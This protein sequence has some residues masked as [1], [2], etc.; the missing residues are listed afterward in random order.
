MTS[1]YVWGHAVRVRAVLATLAVLAGLMTWAPSPAA[2]AVAFQTEDLRVQSGSG[3]DRVELDVTFY[4]PNSASERE[5][6]AAIIFPHGYGGTKEQPK[7]QATKFARLGYFGVTYSARGFGESTGDISLN[8]PEYEVADASTLID[9]LSERPDVLK[10]GE[11][12]PRVGILGGS[13]AGALALLTAA[14]DPRVDVIS[15]SRTWSSLVSALFPNSAGPPAAETPASPATYAGVGVFKKLWGQFFFEGRS[16]EPEGG[17]GG[18][19]GGGNGGEAGECG[20]LRPE[21]CA[22]YEE[23]LQTNRM[24]EDMRAL[25]EKSSPSSVLGQIT[26]PTLLVQGEGDQLFPLAQADA[27]ARGIAAA[28]TPVKLVFVTGG[29]GAFRQNETEAAKLDDLQTRWFDFHLRGTGEDPGTSFDYTVV[30]QTNFTGP[31]E[32]EL[33]TADSY[34]GLTGPGP[35]RLEVP[36]IGEAQEIEYP[37]NGSPGALSSLPP[38]FQ[39]QNGERRGAPTEIPEQSATFESDSLV[40]ALE[41]VGTPVVNVE[42]ASTSGEAVLFGKVYDVDADG[43]ASL[44]MAQVAPARLTNVPA[45]LDQAQSTAIA[46]PAMSYRFAEGHSIRVILT[47]TDQGYATPA[48]EATYQVALAEGE[49]GVLSVPDVTG[50]AAPEFTAR[51]RGGGIATVA[52]IAGGAAVVVLVIGVVTWLLLRRDRRSRR[53]RRRVHSSW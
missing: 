52:L 48:D 31:T 47:S 37:A 34:P 40:D 8:A 53:G 1:Q 51:A 20:G 35:A 25:L 16:L 50:Q 2:A 46:L 17:P 5:P 33:K 18:N 6:A 49:S 44:I 22:A 15:A 29:H 42:V 39:S 24:T 43:A 11:G 13:Y 38:G 21:Y 41:V 19:A 26:A 30:N 28:G 10:D 7:G 36:I 3:A 45:S 12:D 4:I 9:L 14:Y 23:V 27:N 32:G